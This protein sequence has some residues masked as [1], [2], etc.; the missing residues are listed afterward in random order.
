M[1]KIGVNIHKIP[2][3]TTK[4]F[5]RAAAEAG[6]DSLFAPSNVTKEQLLEMARLTR[7]AGM[8]LETLHAPFKGCINHMWL[9]GEEGDAALNTLTDAVTFCHNA[10]VP[11]TV[12]HLSSGEDAPPI[13]DVGR[14]RFARLVAYAREM[15]VKIAFE[16]QR[17]LANIAW[18]FEAFDKEEHVGF[19]WDCGHEGCF[20]PGRHYMPLFGHK[21]F[22]LHLH[23]NDGGYNHDLHQIPFDG[24]LDLDYVARTLRESGF[25]GTVMLE[26]SHGND[27]RYADLTPAEYLQRA[28]NAAKRL[29]DMIEA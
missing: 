24:A 15:G 23:D 7:E 16:N 8:T 27:P 21:L 4:E 11:M 9:E 17:K 5:I 3:A 29:R 1:R 18:A 2:N 28:A 10:G 13:T 19:C 25:P 12:V 6:F 26:I 14:E 22:C 20:T